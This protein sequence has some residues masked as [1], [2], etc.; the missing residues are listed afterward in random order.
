MPFFSSFFNTI[1]NP[2]KYI[3]TPILKSP[4][5]YSNMQIFWLYIE[6]PTHN[7]IILLYDPNHVFHSES[8]NELPLN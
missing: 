2:K 5:P 7:T 4:N 6:I 3:P 8:H 1:L